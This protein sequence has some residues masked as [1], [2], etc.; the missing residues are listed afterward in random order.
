VEPP[1]IKKEGN[2]AGV[3]LAGS[4][5]LGGSPLSVNRADGRFRRTLFASLGA[6]TGPEPR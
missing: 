4:F 2:A 1:P 3:D 6:G 5:I